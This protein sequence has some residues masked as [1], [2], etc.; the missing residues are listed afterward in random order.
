MPRVSA[1]IVNYNGRELLEHTILPS[2]A[3][4]TYTD[5][6]TIVLDD[7]STDD[8]REYLAQHWPAVEVIATG[9][10]NV[11]VSGALNRA[12]R[13]GDGELLALLN[14]D[15]E[16]DP[17]WLETLVDTLDR[18]P[19]AATAVGKLLNF[20]RRDELD[21]TGDR[22][23]WCGWAQRR[24]TGEL[25]DGRFDRPEPVFG[26]CAGAALYR[27]SAFADVGGFDEDFEAYSEDVDWSF[28][29]QL[30]G[31]ATRYEPRALA[32]HMSGATTGRE[33][34]A[35]T[36]L[37]RRNEL[38]V[39]I[40]NYPAIALLR[41]LPKVLLNHGAWVLAHAGSG[42]LRKELR[43]LL[44]VVPE[45]PSVL[46]KRRAIQRRRVVGMDYLNTVVTDEFA[47]GLRL[48]PYLRM[49]LRQIVATRR[50][51]TR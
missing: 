27:R 1:V 44:A 15:I 8:S 48:G 43:A 16:L 17:H 12:T 5:F 22:V 25:D 45:L 41:H 11:G 32:Y 35:Y 21:G 9:P 31:L 47:L 26:A 33:V 18:H 49:R 14:T 38:F 29:A 28:R 34:G 39:V 36:V 46:R 2:L 6:E 19:E 51:H 50:L 20:W 3:A 40:K 10:R 4:Q 23:S 7:H 30:R 24:G 13:L 42:S 37:Q